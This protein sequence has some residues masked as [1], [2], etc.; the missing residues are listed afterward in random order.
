MAIFKARADGVANAYAVDAQSGK[1]IW[2]TKLDD[3][4]SARGTGSGRGRLV[5][6]GIEWQLTCHTTPWRA[7]NSSITVLSWVWYGR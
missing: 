6:D 5:E 1:Q 7:A 3:F 2:K 4:P